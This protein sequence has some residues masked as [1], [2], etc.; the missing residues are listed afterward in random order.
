MLEGV[1]EQVLQKVHGMQTSFAFLYDMETQARG[2]G[3][4]SFRSAPGNAQSLAE[5]NPLFLLEEFIRSVLPRK[6]PRC[7]PQSSRSLGECLPA[8]AVYV[9]HHPE[10]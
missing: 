4:G 2:I 7:H 1:R 3:S 5:A 8:Q 6:W 10:P 9:C